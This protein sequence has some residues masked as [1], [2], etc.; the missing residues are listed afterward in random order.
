MDGSAFGRFAQGDLGR[1][2]T[3]SFGRHEGWHPRELRPGAAKL[4][5]YDFGWFGNR[6]RH[7]Q[8]LA[9]D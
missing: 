8:R 5:C 9:D 2:V 7:V 3:L 1:G 4:H 6:G